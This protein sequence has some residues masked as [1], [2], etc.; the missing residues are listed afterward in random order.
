MSRLSKL[1]VNVNSAYI[2]LEPSQEIEKK[3]FI[4][5]CKL[6]RKKPL[7][8]LFYVT[9]CRVC[10]NGYLYSSPKLPFK[11]GHKGKANA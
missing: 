9:V 10:R 7:T 5:R 3:L 8:P 11:T 1:T 6:R 4:S 2:I